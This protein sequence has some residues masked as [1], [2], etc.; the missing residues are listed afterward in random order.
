MPVVRTLVVLALAGA[1]LLPPAAAVAEE[2]DPD[3]SLADTVPVGPFH[4]A[5]FFG[6]KDFGYDGNTRLGS[7]GGTGDYTVTLGPGARAV[8]PLGRLAALSVWEQID[9]A[10]FARQ[11]DLNHVNNTLRTKLHAYLKDF[12]VYA[13]GEQ[14]S[15]RDRPNSEIDYRIRTTTTQGKVGFNWRPGRRGDADLYVKRTDFHYDAGRPDVPAGA[16]PNQAVLVG[17][18]ISTSLERVETYLGMA[19][20]LRVRPRTSALLDYREG[21]TD[22]ANAVPQRDLSAR[23]VMGGLEFDPAGSLRGYLKAGVKR[24]TPDDQ[25]VRG[26]DGLIADASLSARLLGRGEV[27]ASYQR[28]TGFS[29][30]GDN[31]FYVDDR[32]ALSYEHYLNSR[33]SV[34]LGRQLENVTYPIKVRRYQ[35]TSDPCMKDPDQFSCHHQERKDDILGSRLT[36]R[37]RL[38]PALRVGLS[39]G[40]WERDSTFNSEDADRTTIAT[41][42]EYTP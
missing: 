16:D 8:A 18:I 22:F 38:G 9:Y 26:F 36:F 35:P 20:S 27:R 37:Y 5:P 34:E 11:S 15:T 12:T 31:L 14:V 23:S 32:K 19:G 30:F 39:V 33:L 1:T 10:I 4:M 6:L 29:I 40:R 3:F 17:E 41:L 2:K 7:N 25:A 24:L 28:D 21:R 42:L 13:D